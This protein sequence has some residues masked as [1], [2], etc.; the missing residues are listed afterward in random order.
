ME[1][2]KYRMYGVWGAAAV[3][4]AAALA[5]APVWMTLAIGA[6]CLVPVFVFIKG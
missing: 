6:A 5:G 4:G 3:S 1:K 2:S